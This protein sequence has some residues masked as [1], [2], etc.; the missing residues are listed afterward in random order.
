MGPFI[1]AW[2]VGEGIIVYRNVKVI[3]GPPGP[4]QLLLTSG[5]FALLALA[6]E[7]EQGRSAATMVAWGYDLAAFLN[8]TGKTKVD[9]KA[10]LPMPAPPTVIIPLGGTKL[11]YPTT[12]GSS[13]PTNPPSGGV[14]SV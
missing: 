5:L 9:T 13:N 1:L 7:T 8:I 6:A 12:S 11:P 14:V 10:W 2:L 4:G 3:K